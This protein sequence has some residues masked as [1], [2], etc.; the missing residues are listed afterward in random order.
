MHGGTRSRTLSA[1]DWSTR[2]KKWLIIQQNA[3][4]IARNLNW[5]SNI[6]KKQIISSSTDSGLTIW[7][8]RILLWYLKNITCCFNWFKFEICGKILYIAFL[9]LYILHI[10]SLGKSLVLYGCLVPSYVC[11]PLKKCGKG[12]E[13]YALTF[14][15][16]GCNSQGWNL[17]FGQTPN[18]FF[19]SWR[20]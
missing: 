12:K 13:F 16:E 5:T 14:I 1:R 9:Q 7:Q 17:I 2:G 10:Y 15:Y 19:S 18:L 6:N 8:L 20:Q 11:K 4:E 3:W